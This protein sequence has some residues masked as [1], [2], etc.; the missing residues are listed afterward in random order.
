MTNTHTAGPWFH[1]PSQTFGH[2]GY[3]VEWGV[4]PEGCNLAAVTPDHPAEGQEAGDNEANARLMAAAPELYA[5]LVAL[6]D[7]GETSIIGSEAREQRAEARIQA[8]NALVKATTA[9]A[10]A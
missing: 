5:A 1:R 3:V 2:N 9:P 8:L 7:A 4:G 10:S 6:V